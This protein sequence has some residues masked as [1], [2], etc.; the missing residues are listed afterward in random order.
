MLYMYE[1]LSCLFDITPSE[2]L[3]IIISI[4]KIRTQIEE[5]SNVPKNCGLNPGRW[6]PPA[7]VALVTVGRELFKDLLYFCSSCEQRK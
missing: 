7:S 5:L 2:M 3:P 1:V 6:S 4:L